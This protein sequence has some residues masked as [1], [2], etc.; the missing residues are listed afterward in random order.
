M[1][2]GLSSDSAAEEETVF[3]SPAPPAR[4]DGELVGESP[5]LLAVI[6]RLD[7]LAPGD[8]PVLILGES[9][10]GKELAAR[11]LHRRS[12]R[13][14]RPFVA[15]NCAALSETLLL[16]D[17]FGHVRGAFTGADRDRKGV[18][19]T[20]HGGTVFLDEIG[21]LPL[22]AQGLLLRVLQEGEIRRLGESSSR[23]VDVRVIA[24]THRDLSRMIEEET[25]RRDLYF[26]L[27]VGC[28]EMPPLRERGEDALRIADRFLQTL[29]PPARLTREA[30]ARLL[31]HPWPGNVRELENVLAVA[32]ALAEGRPIGIDHLELPDAEGVTRGTY[33]QQVEAFRRRLVA[34]ALAECGGNQAGAAER[35][36]ISRQTVS[37]LVRQL[38]LG[39]K[40]ISQG[41]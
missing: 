15:V 13:A 4:E 18:F 8:L 23:R 39:S 36:G 6:D 35:L 30:R 24:A 7:R 33:H 20:A 19:E 17:L 11:R 37:Y 14:V 34:Q 16:S 26:R 21:D 3:S 2:Q 5:A 1:L 12:A 32:A 28:V 31:S 9:G 29:A 40:K 22:S 38:G 25:F 27:R 41:P 10:T